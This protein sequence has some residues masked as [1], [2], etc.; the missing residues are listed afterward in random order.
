MFFSKKILKI[1]F[2]VN[3]AL[4][5]AAKPTCFDKYE[6]ADLISIF[7]LVP[8]LFEPNSGN[9][10]NGTNLEWAKYRSCSMMKLKNVSKSAD[11]TNIKFKSIK[12][13]SIFPVKVVVTLKKYHK[14]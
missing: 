10:V 3:T 7:S 2:S 4:T 8:N 13:K 5:R 12:L 14:A 9:P 6:K 11:L 1:S